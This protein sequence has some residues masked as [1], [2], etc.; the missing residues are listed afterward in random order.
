V[1]FEKSPPELIAR[2]D[3]LAALA[4]DA[5]RKLMF[6]FPSLVLGG[7]MVMGLYEDVL[8]L[9]LGGEDRAALMAGGGQVFS[10]MAGRP[11][12]DFVVVPGAL[13]ADTE[14]MGDWVEKA[15][16]YAARLPPKKPKPAKAAKKS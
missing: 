1:P 15:L 2:F 16:G 4:P 12:K 11:M 8:V 7:H 6:G 5:T 13:L 14:A 10:P 9:R 3:E